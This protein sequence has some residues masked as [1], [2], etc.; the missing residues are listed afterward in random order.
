MKVLKILLFFALLPFALYGLVWLVAI[1]GGIAYG[2][3][4]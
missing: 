1:V 3:S 4:R 2:L